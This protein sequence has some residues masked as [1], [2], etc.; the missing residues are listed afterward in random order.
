MKKD[1]LPVAQI[2]N[3]TK[4]SIEEIEKLQLKLNPKSP[5]IPAQNKRQKVIYWLPNDLTCL[6]AIFFTHSF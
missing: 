1:G 5:P 3:F 6:D 2:S 4:L